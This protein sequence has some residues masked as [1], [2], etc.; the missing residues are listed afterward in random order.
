MRGVGA[1]AL[2]RPVEQL[3]DQQQDQRRACGD[4]HGE[5]TQL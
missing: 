2:Q 3:H 4:R 1:M 5:H